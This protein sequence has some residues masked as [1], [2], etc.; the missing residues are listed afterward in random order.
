MCVLALQGT[1]MTG[2]LTRPRHS[3]AYSA[4]LEPRPTGWALLAPVIATNASRAMARQTAQRSVVGLAK[5]ARTA[6]ASGRS[7]RLAP[8]APPPTSQSTLGASTRC[9]LPSLPHALVLTDLPTACLTGPVT[10][11]VGTFQRA[12]QGR[13][14]CATTSPMRRCA[15]RYA[16]GTASLLRMCWTPSS[17]NFAPSRT[18]STP[19]EHSLPAFCML[20]SIGPA[21]I[22]CMYSMDCLSSLLYPAAV[23]AQCTMPVT[24]KRLSHTLLLCL[25]LR[26]APMI[27]FKTLKAGAP[28]QPSGAYVHYQ[29]ANALSVGTQTPAPGAQDPTT[30]FTDYQQCRDACDQ[31]ATCVGWTIKMAMFEADRPRTCHL[32]TGVNDPAQQARSFIRADTAHLQVP[33]LV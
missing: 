7:A 28:A 1:T 12:Q 14:S 6:K 8:I 23:I 27:A 26:R 18:L 2:P 29:D 15:C 9:L 19:G 3:P 22:A 21:L 11:M 13:T 17:A 24:L 20:R 33:V 25:Q 4:Q 31:D 30:P 10:A 32:V 16:R 5:Q